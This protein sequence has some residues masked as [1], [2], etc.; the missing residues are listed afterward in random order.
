MYPEAVVAEQ[1]GRV[2][3]SRMVL[4]DNTAQVKLLPF[5]FKPKGKIYLAFVKRFELFLLENLTDT[6]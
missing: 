3:L 6:K 5:I 1:L 4:L 2:L